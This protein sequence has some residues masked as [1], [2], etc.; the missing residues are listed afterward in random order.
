MIDFTERVG[1]EP[2]VPFGYTRSPGAPLRPLGHLSRTHTIPGEKETHSPVYGRMSGADR[3]GLDPARSHREACRA[4]W[5]GLGRIRSRWLAAGEQLFL[6]KAKPSSYRDRI[7][8]G[9]V[10][11]GEGGIRTHG[12][13]WVHTLSRRAPST[14]RPPLRSSASYEPS[15]EH[16]HLSQPDFQTADVTMSSAPWRASA[17]APSHYRSACAAG[18]LYERWAV[19]MSEMAVSSTAPATSLW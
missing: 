17:L 13:R 10:W 18:R 7:P 4:D 15:A 5:G 8:P 16:H 3:L 12:T 9:G 14:A 11:S 2:T 19:T 1:F 6:M